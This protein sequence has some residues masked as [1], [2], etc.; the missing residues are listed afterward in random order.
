MNKKEDIKE[1]AAIARGRSLIYLWLSGFFLE[2]PSD[3]MFTRLSNRDILNFLD[4]VF[5]GSE[6]YDKVKEFL[7]NKDVDLIKEEFDLLFNEGSNL[8][9][10]P[11]AHEYYGKEMLGLVKA[12]YNSLGLEVDLRGLKAEDHIGLELAIMAS[13]CE[14]E[15]EELERERVADAAIIQEGERMFLTDHLTKWV[16]DFARAVEEK[17]PDSFYASLAQLTNELIDLDLS[18][19]KES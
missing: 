8:Y 7:L 3:E 5:Q 11:Y 4:G 13:L 17:R 6:N 1:I 9:V 19:F 14:L 15:A 10:S 2:E 16:G 18:L 12:F